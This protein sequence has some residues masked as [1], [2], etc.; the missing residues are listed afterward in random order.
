[1]QDQQDQPD[2]LFRA[3]A[4]AEVMWKLQEI[5][6]EVVRHRE[7]C[8]PTP[9][10][11]DMQAY[12][13]HQL[14][15]MTSVIS[16]LEWE[17]LEHWNLSFSCFFDL[18]ADLVLNAATDETEA[19]QRHEVFRTCL[20][21]TNLTFKLLFP[22]HLQKH[23]QPR[24]IRQQTLQ[25]DV[26][27]KEQEIL[28]AMKY[29]IWR[30]TSTSWTR[31]FMD[32]LKAKHGK[33]K[34]FERWCAELMGNLYSLKLVRPKEWYNRRPREI[35]NVLFSQAAESLQLEEDLQKSCAY[36]T[37]VNLECFT[38]RPADAERPFVQI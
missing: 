33:H 31:V 21:V 27:E 20:A 17:Q 3:G 25:L 1:M 32:R 28:A 8:K 35:A 37:G 38:R 19:S 11:D 36:I 12:A 13:S 23:L 4:S 9:L 15:V 26:C 29:R 22:E 24:S 18:D 14:H 30:P 34:V 16:G 7:D 5:E 2:Q 10:P 6:D